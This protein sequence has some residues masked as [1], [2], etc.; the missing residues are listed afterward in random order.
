[1]RRKISDKPSDK[2]EIRERCSGRSGRGRC[3]RGQSGGAL[4]PAHKTMSRNER[5]EAV[6]G[7]IRAHEPRA[8]RP[9]EHGVVHAG[10]IIA[11]LRQPRRKK[12]IRS[13]FVLW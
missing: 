11:S 1:M 3:P 9:F 10:R 13:R 8:F 6:G 2:K 5:P 4:L 7:W 12:N